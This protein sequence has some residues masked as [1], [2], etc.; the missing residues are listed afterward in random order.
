MKKK[1]NYQNYLS[2]ILLL[3]MSYYHCVFGELN[4]DFENFY[5]VEL[6]H[7]FGTLFMVK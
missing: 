3:I 5:K 4:S 6:H 2:L 1:A 7:I